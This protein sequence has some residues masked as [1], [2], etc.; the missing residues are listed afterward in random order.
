M[1]F[2]IFMEYFDRYDRDEDCILKAIYVDE[3]DHEW[4]GTVPS[5]VT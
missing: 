2:Y 1:Y 3:R 4:E 5:Q